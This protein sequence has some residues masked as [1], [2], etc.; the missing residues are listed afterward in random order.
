MK[1]IPKLIIALFFSVLLCIPSA[2]AIFY[3][4]SPMEDV[5]YNLSVIM[6]DGQEKW[7]GDMGWTVYTNDKGTQK[8]LHPDGMGGYTGLDY[9]GQTFYFSR[10]LT[11]KMDDPTLKVGVANRSISIFLDDDLLYT[12]CPELDNRIGYLTLPMQDYDRTEPVTISLPPDYAQRILT[13]AQSTEALSEKGTETIYPLEAT[14]YCGYAYESGLIASTSRTMLPAALLFALELFL[15]MAFIWNTFNGTLSF[16][17]PVFALVIL[18]QMCSTLSRAEFFYEY[19][20]TPSLDPIWLFFH[21]SVSALLLFLTLYA[22]HGRL[23]FSLITAFHMSSTLLYIF[24]QTGLLPVNEEQYSIFSTFPQITGFFALSAALAGAFF[25]WKRGNTFFRHLAQSALILIIGYLLFLAASIPLSTGYTATVFSRIWDETALGLPNFCLKLVWKLSL[26]SSLAAI[27][28][29]LLEHEAERRTEKA[30]LSAKNE[31]AIESY[32]N[33]RR[34]SEEVMILRH[35]TFKHYSL[36]RTMAK[37][38]PHRL[39]NYLDELIGQTESIRPVV[40]SRNQILN[41]LLNGKLNFAANKGIATEIVRSGA[42]K[43]LP[44]TD[45]ELCCLIMNILDNAINAA[46]E[47]ETPYIKLDFHCKDRHFVFCCENSVSDKPYSRKK[48]PTPEHGY[49]LKIIRQIMS[50][51]GDNMIS[52]SQSDSIYKI[53]VII[54]LFS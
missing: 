23:L 8:E 9:P 15:L 48:I 33:L 26:I 19:F 3:Y 36:L 6:E 34:Q 1:Q 42:P 44:L 12:D 22:V 27:I 45:T 52:I 31:L 29:E 40:S 2:A 25:L 39:I 28:I 10:K 30:I 53:T 7:Q 24:T 17:I 50:H 5:S 4:T 38:A 49:G 47:A 37:D 32:E 18:F 46:A 35:D 14:L 51:F 11:E 21:L 13:I 16:R 43:K 20:G 41:I 54:P